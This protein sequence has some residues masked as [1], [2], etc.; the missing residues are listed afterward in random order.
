MNLTRPTFASRPRSVQVGGVRPSHTGARSAG[1]ST[2]AARRR[3]MCATSRLASSSRR[4]PEIW[5][6]PETKSTRI[7]PI[8]NGQR[9]R[10]GRKTMAKQPGT[11]AAVGGPRAALGGRRLGLRPAGSEGVGRTQ[12]ASR[13]RMAARVVR[14]RSSLR[15]RLRFIRRSSDSAS[16]GRP[17]RCRGNRSAHS[18]RRSRSWSRPRVAWSDT[19]R[20]GYGGVRAWV[21]IASISAR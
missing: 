5:T 9:T 11:P 14:D 10:C 1:R 3:R 7:G 18:L 4:P 13:E 19:S 12:S 20:R 21:T 16:S 15:N 6:L 17:G 2:G 8:P